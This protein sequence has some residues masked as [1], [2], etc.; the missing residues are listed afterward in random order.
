M[1]DIDG[2][3]EEEDEEAPVGEL[4]ASLEKRIALLRLRDVSDSIEGLL[5]NTFATGETSPC[6]LTKA[7]LHK[8]KCSQSNNS[9]YCSV[10]S[11][12]AQLT[13]QYNSARAYSQELL[14][15]DEG[16]EVDRFA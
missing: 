2:S 5:K 14:E 15:S 12:N 4:M 6:S 11:C 16:P 3:G 7:S 13:L 10:P 9:I 1:I 8:L